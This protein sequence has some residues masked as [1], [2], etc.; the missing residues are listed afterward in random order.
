MEF[1]EQK[2]LARRQPVE[3][4]GREQILG[5]TPAGKALVPKLAAL[6]DANDEHFFGHLAKSER[7]SLKSLMQALVQHH[8][9]K[10]TPTN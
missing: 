5:L 1:K 6:A 2:G 3:G 4:S 9:L 7:D 10:E 8:Q